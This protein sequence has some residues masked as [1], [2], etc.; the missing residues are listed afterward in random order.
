MFSFVLVGAKNGF[1]W[2]LTVWAP[3][4]GGWQAE[5][6]APPDSTWLYGGTEGKRGSG[7]L[8]ESY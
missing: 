1:V 2:Y 4:G 5:A 3:N 6:P 7:G 8:G